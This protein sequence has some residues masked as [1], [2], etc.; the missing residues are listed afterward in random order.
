M[1]YEKQK[2]T[3]ERVATD[4]NEFIG[5]EFD[6]CDLTYSGGIRPRFKG[7]TFG[8]VRWRFLGPAGETMKLAGLIYNEGGGPLLVQAIMQLWA[9][10]QQSAA[11]PQ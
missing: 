9:E 10:E 11:S 7:N 4:G 3:G 8:E 5:C 2:F 1:R 6:D